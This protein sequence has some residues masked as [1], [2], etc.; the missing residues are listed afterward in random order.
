MHVESHWFPTGRNAGRIVLKLTGVDTI[1]QAETVAGAEIEIPSDR[2]LTLEEGSF[3]VTDLI[4]CCVTD[5][6]ASLGT[7]A[8]IQ[9][10][11]DRTGRKMEDAPALFVLRDSNGAEILVP[12]ANAFVRRIDVATKVIEMTLPEGL[13]ELNR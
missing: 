9:M 5:G 3:Y 6:Q 12:F 10:T 2:R 13:L 7:V 8:D 11:F 1:T 4:G